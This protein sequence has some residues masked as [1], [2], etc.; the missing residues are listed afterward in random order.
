MLTHA[1]VAWPRPWLRSLILSLA[2]QTKNLDARKS[3]VITNPGTLPIRRVFFWAFIFFSSV[4]SRALKSYFMHNLIFWFFY[5]KFYQMVLVLLKP[6]C[7]HLFWSLC[8]R[9]N[10]I[11]PVFLPCWTFKSYFQFSKLQRTQ[12]WT[13]GMNISVPISDCFLSIQFPK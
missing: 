10:I 5:L 8:N 1:H 6:L 13:S 3:T 11:F 9:S 2:K 4:F 12:W 7:V